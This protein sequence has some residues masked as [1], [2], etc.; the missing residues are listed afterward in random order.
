MLAL[1]NDDHVTTGMIAVLDELLCGSDTA[2]VG[3][4][5]MMMA[6]EKLFSQASGMF[7]MQFSP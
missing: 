6:K 1:S 4:V 5:T 7:G 2:G 3:G